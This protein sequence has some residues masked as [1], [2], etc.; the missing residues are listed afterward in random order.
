MR[1]QSNKTIFESS[2]GLVYPL[3]H[4]RGDSKEIECLLAEN[5]LQQHKI[6]HLEEIN[7]ALEKQLDLAHQNIEGLEANNSRLLAYESEFIKLKSDCTYFAFLHSLTI[8]NE[9]SK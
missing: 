9:S 6:E 1:E 5:K 4:P 7:M 3:T 8:D 2:K